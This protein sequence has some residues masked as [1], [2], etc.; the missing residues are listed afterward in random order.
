MARSEFDLEGIVAINRNK[1]Q[2]ANIS[3]R[4]STDGCRNIALPSTVKTILSASRTHPHRCE[5]FFSLVAGKKSL[6]AGSAARAC[7][8]LSRAFS[9]ILPVRISRRMKSGRYYPEGEKWR[10][11]RPRPCSAGC[12]LIFKFPQL[13]LGSC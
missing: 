6:P 4:T 1:T 9:V 13:V 8:K 3:P 5:Y 2:C 11:T 10:I 7:D 12:N